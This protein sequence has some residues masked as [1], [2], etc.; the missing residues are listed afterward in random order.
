M[1]ILIA[2]ASG[3]LGTRLT[4]Q[5]RAAGHDVVRLVRRPTRDADEVR[6]DPGAG[7]LD[8]A[9]LAGAGAAVNLAGANIGDRRW[10]QGFKEVLRSSRVDS[11][12]TLARA[13]AALPVEQRPRVLLNGS[14]IGWYGDTGDR[15]VEEGEPA[16]D[17]FMADL[18][19][20]W[21][22]AT[23]PAEQAGVRVVRLRTGLPLEHTGGLLKPQLLPYRL[24]IAGRFGSGR[25]WIPWIS[26]ADWL[27]ATTF[28]LDREDIAGPVNVVGPA[29]VTNAEFTRELGRLLHRPTVMPVP[30]VALRVLLGEMSAEPLRS[31]RVMPGV[32]NRAGFEFRHP[33]LRSALE[34][35]LPDR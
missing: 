23:A 35:A 32:L 29:P 6:W 14:A 5:L 1:R 21:E 20:V 9:A 24:G 27:A 17:G 31:L 10:T 30:A 18:C 22:A 4:D 33:D 15:P 11:T 19:R 7:Q 28:L 8:P 16:G 13:L 34:A 25:Q 2:G 12:G 26:M 3:W